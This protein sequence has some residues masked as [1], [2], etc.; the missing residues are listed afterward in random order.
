MR[1]LIISALLI[2]LQCGKNPDK[3]L[4][5]KYDWKD[6][7]IT[8]TISHEM[9]EFSFPQ[10]PQ[11][12]KWMMEIILYHSKSDK[13][14]LYLTP[15]TYLTNGNKIKIPITLSDSV[16]VNDI[17]VFLTAA[18]AEGMLFIRHENYYELRSRVRYFYPDSL[19][20]KLVA[21]DYARKANWY[22][23]PYD[24]FAGEDSSYYKAKMAQFL[25]DSCGKRRYP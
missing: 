15:K 21:M 25:K 16:S 6:S 3:N 5:S 7:V 12:K 23:A 20:R 11:T 1:L 19:S 2:F 8:Y 22:M 10:T 13:D 17:Q 9:I 14:I 18:P 24:L 4:L